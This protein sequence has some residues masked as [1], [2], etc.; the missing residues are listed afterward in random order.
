MLSQTT[1]KTGSI[2]IDS[3]EYKFDADKNLTIKI[4]TSSDHLIVGEVYA[5]LANVEEKNIYDNNLNLIEDIFNNT[6]LFKATSKTSL[7]HVVKIKSGL[8]QT[9]NFLTLND[10]GTDITV[11]IENDSIEL[12]AGVYLFKL[13]N[14]INTDFDGATIK[15][16]ELKVS[17]DGEEF[18]SGFSKE[19]S[20]DDSE[21]YDSID[22][23]ELTFDY[24]VRIELNNATSNT[25]IPLV[26]IRK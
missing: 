20:D 18:Y 17:S 13:T 8:I 12:D 9:E 5:T 19:Y 23:Q 3:L 7:E 14:E 24:K 2:S 1:L 26:I 10:N 21:L 25:N 4:N 6:F 22:D 11:D 15:I 16:S